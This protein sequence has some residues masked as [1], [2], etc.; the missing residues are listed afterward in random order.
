M[1]FVT[2]PGGAQIAVHDFGGDGPDVLFA[3]AT[4]FHGHEWLPVIERLRDRF[5][6]VAFDE[7]GHGESPPPPDGDYSWWRFADDAIAVVD[8]LGLDPPFGVGH[9]CGGA[10]L[11]MA[12]ETRPGTFRSLWCYE[13]IVFPPAMRPGGTSSPNPLVAG[14][15]RRR[16]VFPSR[17][18]A[19]ANYAAKPPFSVLSPEGLAAYVDHGFEDL[20]D[21]TVQLRCR[22]EDEARTYEGAS[23][24]GAFARLGEV[25][26]PVVLVC[27]GDSDVLRSETIGLQAAPLRNGRT[28]VLDGLT[29]FGPLQDP[30]A[31]AA[32][33]S[34]A[35]T[36][37]SG[38]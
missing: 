24:D 36:T 28:E 32:S 31:V 25:Q 29:H 18:A 4:G 9:S 37:A 12:E 26:C 35:L 19:A 8:A 5:R 1:P 21:G 38:G 33:V 16:E 20:S 23:P 30:D 7:R 22:G 6:C 10:L 34:R 2:G 13:A 11:L 14:A 3:H 17:E 15:R 27:G